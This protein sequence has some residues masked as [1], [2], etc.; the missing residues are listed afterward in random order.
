[1]FK[2][3]IKNTSILSLGTFVSR[4]L[5]FIRDILVANIFGTSAVLEAFVVAFRLPNLFR[6][7]FAE[8]IGDSVATPVLSEYQKEKKELFR[9]GSNLLSLFIAAV[10]IF[11]VLG[12][13]FSKYLVMLIAP[14]FIA[15]PDKFQLAV[16]FTRITFIYLFLIGISIN[17]SSILYS[18]KKFLIP[19][20]NPA[21]LNIAFIIGLLLLSGVFKTYILVGCVVA[22]GLLQ[23]VF[24]FI[25]LKRAGFRFHFDL[26]GALKDKAIK[27]MLKLFPARIWSSITYHLSVIVD[28]IF[29]SLTHIVGE[30]ALAAVW[31]ANRLVQ[32]PLA[33]IVL[34]ISRVA[35]VDLSYYHKEGNIEDFKKLFV[36]SF[37]NII[38]FIVPVSVIFLFLSQ[39][40]IDV[41]FK[42]GEFSFYSL[43]IT[44]SVLFFYSFGLFF[45]CTI[46]L[47]VNAFY[48]L[49]DTITPAKTTTISLVLNIILSAILIFPLKI[50]GV[51]LG[52]SLAA[53]FNSFLLYR[54][55]LRRLGPIDWE[56]TKSQFIKV[57]FLSLITAV[58][59]W[60]LWN[61][62]MLNKYL[63]MAIAA[64]ASSCIFI[65]GGYILKIKQINFIKEL[66][67]NNEK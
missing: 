23:L 26:K 64:A 41:I 14:G 54:Y 49:K 27:R 65:L 25:S 45:F 28:T 36:F 30:G 8:G 38:F 37:Q 46:K 16:S 13:I 62:I 51:A 3:F 32:F 24:P 67:F 55:L 43:K 34:P 1:M 6:S 20:I 40:L 35:I 59:A 9:I 21:F 44:S 50:G 63:R 5:G 33:L 22:G 17:S 12:I 53:I 47:L 18:L 11:T 60:L 56:D 7:I 42:R 48:S 39:G 61:N 57:L 4:V 66:I 52:S 29:S 58:V 31:Y 15:Q 2:K 19:A 10:L